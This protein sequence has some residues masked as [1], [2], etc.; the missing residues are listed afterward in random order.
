MTIAD[1]AT[2]VPPIRDE[3]ELA[4]AR[5]AHIHRV[6]KWTLPSL[7]MVL[8]ILAW[9]LYV[10]IAEVPHYILPGPVLVAQKMVEDWA[11]LWPAMIVTS[12]LTLLALAMA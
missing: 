6:A 4:R 11:L 12:R 8:T 5:T 3:E 10:T 2:N 7:V 1:P 9:H